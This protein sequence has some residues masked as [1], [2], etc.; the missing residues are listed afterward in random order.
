MRPVFWAA[1]KV[2]RTREEIVYKKRLPHQIWWTTTLVPPYKRCKYYFELH[3]DDQVWYYL[4]DGF[5]T[6]ES[7]PSGRKD[8]AVFCCAVD[9]SGRRKPDASLGK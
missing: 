6:E 9:E 8:A 5:L 2:D 3:T 4:E 1:I 7:D